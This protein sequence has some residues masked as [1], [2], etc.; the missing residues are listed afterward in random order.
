MNNPVQ[1][2]WSA[3]FAREFH[4]GVFKGGY[5]AAVAPASVRINAK[6]LSEAGQGLRHLTID[7]MVSLTAAHDRADLFRVLADLLDSQEG[8]GAFAALAHQ[9][10][11]ES[12]DL[13]R[14]IDTA[15]QDGHL[16]LREIK[17]IQAHA[18]RN[19]QNASELL[20][21]ALRLEPGEIDPED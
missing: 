4:I 5:A 11:Y 12:A 17:D 16:C 9:D 7:E 18:K 15:E 21:R 14:T 3:W 6:K 13:A 2:Q 10:V 8:P 1:G 20:A 19:A